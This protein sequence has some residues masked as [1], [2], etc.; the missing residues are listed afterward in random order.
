MRRGRASRHLDIAPPQSA[1]AIAATGVIDTPPP[2]SLPD[3][4]V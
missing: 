1:G 4:I 2:C 3:P